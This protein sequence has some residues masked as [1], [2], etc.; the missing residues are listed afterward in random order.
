[1]SA[2]TS[3]VFNFSKLCLQPRLYTAYCWFNYNLSF[4]CMLF[5]CKLSRVYDMCFTYVAIASL[6]SRNPVI[7]GTAI[8]QSTY[9][10]STLNMLFTVCFNWNILGI[11]YKTPGVIPCSTILWILPN[12]HEKEHRSVQR[13]WSSTVSSLRLSRAVWE[14]LAS[15]PPCV[16]LHESGRFLV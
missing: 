6:T 10:E 14:Y 11:Q 16:K 15:R 9:S 8:L 7:T 12:V 5:P 1:M 13:S 3:I 2:D 4:S